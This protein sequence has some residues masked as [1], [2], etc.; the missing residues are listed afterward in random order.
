MYPNPNNPFAFL[1]NVDMGEMTMLQSITAGMDQPRLATFVNAYATR[2]KDPNT[3]LLTDLIGFLGIA[4]IHRF[5]LDSVGMG[6]LYL[7]TGG[8][9]GIGTIIDAINYRNLTLDYNTKAAQQ[10]LMMLGMT[11]QHYMP[12]QPP[13]QPPTQQ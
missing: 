11:Q 1:P 2:R 13:T 5:L 6:I 9:C 8:L 10:T 4:G 3:I 12:P 7:L